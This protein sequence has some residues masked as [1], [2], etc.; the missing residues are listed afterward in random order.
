MK[1]ALLKQV[2]IS[3]EVQGGGFGTAPCN[4]GICGYVS[5]ETIR[6]KIIMD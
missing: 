2:W 1:V 5:E 3:A 6:W 4:T